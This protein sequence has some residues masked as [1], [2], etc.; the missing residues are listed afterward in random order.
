MVIV[1]SVL[2]NLAFYVVTGV[3]LVVSAPIFIF[4]SQNA[5][6]T[7]VRNW[8]KVCIYLHDKLA[9]GAMEVRGAENIPTGAALVAAKHQSSYETFALIPLLHNPTIVMKKSIRWFPIFGP[10]TVKT[11]MIHVDREGKTAALRALSERAREEAGKGRE[12]IIFPEGTR[13]PV[14][15]PPDYQTGIALLYRTLNVPVVPVALNSGLAWPRRSFLHYPEKIIVEF[16][17]AIPPGLDS[18]AFLARLQ[19]AVE[20]ASKRLVAEGR[21]ASSRS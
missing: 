6:M 19:D 21:T 9:G 2:F 10:Y 18:R 20:T 8:A 1:R 17:P 16:L 12:I 5:G 13:R 3:M 4:G 11:G 14:D 7:V 15:A